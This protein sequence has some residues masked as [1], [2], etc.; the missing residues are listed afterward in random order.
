VNIHPSAIVHPSAE[1]GRD[2]QIGPYSIVGEKVTIGDGTWIANGVVVQRNTR[3]G[4]ACR[5]YTGAVLGT[6]PQDLKYKGEETFLEIGDRTTIREFT[7]VNLG[8]AQRGKTTIGNDAMLM[9]Y[10][11]VA[12]DCDIRDHV[13]LANAV[14]MGGHVEIHE[15]A[16]VGGVVPIH[17]FVRIGCHAMIGG[18]YRVNQDVCPYVR[19]A[20]YPLRVV[21]LNT[22]GLRRRGF[23]SETLTLL[24]KAY[25]LLFNCNLNVSQAVKRITG[26][27]PKTVEIERIVHFVT[28]SQ[29]GIVR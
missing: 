15:H 5:I 18:G 17:Q 26:E 1:L 28:N 25:S 24:K 6:E 20:G 19:V 4:S 13:I 12:H 16:V 27:L 14:N 9:S 10:V 21:G 23:S 2:V 7:T 22:V 8:T 3:I 11:H 29:R